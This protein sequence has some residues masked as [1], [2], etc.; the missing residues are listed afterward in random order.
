M[1]IHLPILPVV[2]AF[3]MAALLQV[4]PVDE[5]ETP[6]PIAAPVDESVE[7]PVLSTEPELDLSAQPELIASAPL[8]VSRD[9]ILV[10]AGEAL[11]TTRTAKGAFIQT[12]TYGEKVSGNFYIRRPGRIRFEY[13]S[14]AELLVISDG[15]T[16]SYQDMALET[17]DR[18]PVSATPLK[19]F[20]SDDVELSDDAN[21]IDVQ[22]LG[23]R[24]LVVVED[25]RSGD[26]ERIE[27]QLVLMFEKDTFDLLG[28][29]ANDE[30]GGRTLV[31]L[32][33]VETG[34]RLNPRLFRLENEEDD[35]RR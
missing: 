22:S 6:S 18:I 33:G 1:M 32:V 10:K 15:S 3:G 21:V 13:G 26:E 7:T 5:Q 16:V 4:S 9:E 29:W 8:T 25:R 30:T 12:D 19:L 11:R 20:L 2:A 23:D 28:W 27:G 24:H 34:V 17:D 31:E 35:R 14:P